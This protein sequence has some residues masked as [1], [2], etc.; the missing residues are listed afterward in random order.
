[1]KKKFKILC[2]QTKSS[3]DP[4]KNIN[5]LEDLFKRVSLKVDL[6]CLPECVG[7]FSDEKKNINLFLDKFRDSFFNLIKQQAIQKK[8]CIQVG[9]VPEKFNDYKFVNRSYI[10][11]Q[12]GSYNSFYDKINLFDVKLTDSE[13]YYES[14]NYISGKKVVVSNLPIGKLGMSICYDLRFPNLYKKLAKKGADFFSIPAAF[15]YTTG[16]AHWH[17]LI[18]AR[19]IENGCFVFAA[20]QNGIHDN[21]RKTFG[22]SMIVNPWGKILA[23]AKAKNKFIISEINL[24]EIKL[25]RKKIPSMTSYEK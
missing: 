16:K 7:V 6:I 18:R 17:S 3:K 21:G 23:E 15:T 11:D 24:D 19:A 8:C 9:S 5:M 10:V 20:A 12:K 22:H 2:L 1:M 14:K 25:A 13:Y 4:H